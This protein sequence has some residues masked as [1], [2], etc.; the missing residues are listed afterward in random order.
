MKELEEFVNEAIKQ[1]PE[2]LATL[3]ELK[4]ILDETKKKEQKFI[5]SFS[6]PN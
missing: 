1:K 4:K 6:A 3:D 5:I 2:E